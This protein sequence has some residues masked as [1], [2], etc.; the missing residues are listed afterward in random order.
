MWIDVNKHTPL[1]NEVVHVLGALEGEEPSEIGTA[2]W[3][4]DFW[5][6]R[7]GDIDGCEIVAWQSIDAEPNDLILTR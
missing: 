2:E 7:S 6:K 4:G 1:R 3:T 5:L